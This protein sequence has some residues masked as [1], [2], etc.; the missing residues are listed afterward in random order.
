MTNTVNSA[1]SN[2]GM[3]CFPIVD[4]R[5]T[6]Y[7]TRILLRTQ[8]LQE[9]GQVL[10]MLISLCKNSLQDF[11]RSG[12]IHTDIGDHFP[13]AVRSR[14]ARQLDLPY[15]LHQLL[16]FGIFRAAPAREPFRGLIRLLPSWTMRSAT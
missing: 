8:L 3:N 12:V 15:H 14:S 13:K 1:P 11:P 4:P 10:C 9:A 7:I 16:S 2:R 5:L 6:T